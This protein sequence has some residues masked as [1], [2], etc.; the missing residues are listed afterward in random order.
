MN[1]EPWE[2]K[3]DQLKRRS[4]KTRKWRRDQKIQ[5][6]KIFKQIFRWTRRIYSK[7]LQDKEHHRV[8][9]KL[10]MLLYLKL[11][12]ATA[13]SNRQTSSYKDIRLT[14]SSFLCNVRRTIAIIAIKAVYFQITKICSWINNSLQTTNKNII[15]TISL[16]PTWRHNQNK[17]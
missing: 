6:K 11:I 16:G 9:V 2:N 14:N 3:W 4:A 12:K 10:L 13:C 15:R 7:L 8:T 1:N 5:I 17:K